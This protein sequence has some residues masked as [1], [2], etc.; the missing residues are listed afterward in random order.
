[1]NPSVLLLSVFFSGLL[2]VLIDQIIRQQLL[3]KTYESGKIPPQCIA[4]RR[5]HTH[6]IS[7]FILGIVVFPFAYWLHNYINKLSSPL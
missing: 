3:E 6:L 7:L 2:T 1:M 5:T 4:Y